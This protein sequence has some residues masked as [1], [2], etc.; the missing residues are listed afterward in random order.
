MRDDLNQL[1]RAVAEETFEGLAFMFSMGDESESGASDE[2]AWAGVRFSGPFSG[3][4]TLAVSRR[5]LP[6]LAGNMLGLDDSESAT[7]DQQHDGLKELANVVCGNLLPRIA[8]KQVVF[9]IAA[10]ELL[11]GEASPGRAEQAATACLTLDEGEARIALL[12]EGKV[13]SLA[14]EAA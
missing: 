8:G 11:A 14:G 3:R 1:L 7:A 5:A 9:E 13:P 10:P 2:M 12:I 4:L 6:A